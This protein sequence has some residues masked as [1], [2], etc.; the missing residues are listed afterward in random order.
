LPEGYI[1]L[2]RQHSLIGCPIEGELR[3]QPYWFRLW[4]ADE[5][6]QANLDY[7]VQE[8]MPGWFAFGSSGGGEIFAFDTRTAQ[9]WKVYIV[10]CI[11][12]NESEAILIAEDL[13]AFIKAI[14]FSQ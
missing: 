2:L 1:N 10:P 8:F 14:I 12:I 5:V 13:E 9:P 3:I 11:T 6:L 4:A 7:R